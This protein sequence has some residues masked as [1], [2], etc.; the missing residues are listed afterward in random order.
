MHEGD[1]FSAK[2]LGKSL[3]CCQNDCSSHGLAG[4]FW[5]LEGALRVILNPPIYLLQYHEFLSCY[6]LLQKIL[7]FII[8]QLPQSGTIVGTIF[9]VKTILI[10][11]R[12]TILVTN[13]HFKRNNLSDNATNHNMLPFKCPPLTDIINSMPPSVMLLLT[14]LN[15]A[16]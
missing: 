10:K 7:E 11:D 14:L 9:I 15:S 12:E 6:S 8:V 1:G 4:Q 2:T 5:L 16:P 13:P 3:F